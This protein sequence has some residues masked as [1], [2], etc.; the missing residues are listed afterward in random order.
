MC[1]HDNLPGRKVLE[2][3]WFV[4]QRKMED[5]KYGSVLFRCIRDLAKQGGAKALLITSTPQATGFWLKHLSNLKDSEK[6]TTPGEGRAPSEA[7]GTE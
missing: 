4:T 3:I 7:R 5:K 2:L 1:E 6:F